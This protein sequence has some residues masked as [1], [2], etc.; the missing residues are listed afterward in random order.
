MEKNPDV[1]RVYRKY[2]FASFAAAAFVSAGII[3]LYVN[4]VAKP[5]FS[6]LDALFSLEGLRRYL[7]NFVGAIVILFIVIGLVSR[8]G[9][10]KFQ[11]FHEI[12]IGILMVCYILCLV[13]SSISA[14]AAFLAAS[15]CTCGA[16]VWTV[17]YDMLLAGM[18]P[19]IILG[20]WLASLAAGFLPYQPEF[21]LNAA[22]LASLA[23]GLTPFLFLTWTL[24]AMLYHPGLL[25]TFWRGEK[26]Q[27]ERFLCPVCLR[28]FELGP[29]LPWLARNSGRLL[30][31]EYPTHHRK[32]RDYF[33]CR[34]C[35]GG[36]RYE[37]A[38]TVVAVIDR[39]WE[40]EARRKGSTL[41]INAMAGNEESLPMDLD[42]LEIRNDPEIKYDYV[43]QH[44]YL[45]LVEDHVVRSDDLKDKIPVILRN[46]PPI[47][48]NT[49]HLIAD[50][51]KEIAY[52]PE[53]EDGAAPETYI[54]V[55]SVIDSDG[56]TKKKR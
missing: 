30:A 31:K 8:I 12:I 28:R 33:V 9:V 14:H 38:E 23:A 7:T 37:N 35:G 46:N 5:Y 21:S 17:I 4:D 18:K 43:L 34:S 15:A 53:K 26:R 32:F 13:A 39:P 36:D 25:P 44:Y 29:G 52:D 47:S 3:L 56:D 41:Y 24:A 42:A 45:T 1:G 16:V 10:E 50:W 27:G 51:F 55:K 6:S 19:R 48:A 22:Y 11:F 49:R 54:S 40:H 2:V 20:L